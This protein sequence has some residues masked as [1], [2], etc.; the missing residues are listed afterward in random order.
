MRKATVR[1]LHQFAVDNKFERRA[2]RTMR[3]VYNRLSHR[4]KY[5]FKQ[6]ATEGD[7]DGARKLLMSVS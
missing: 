3:R 1:V 2:E 6:C 4:G 7:V 5:A